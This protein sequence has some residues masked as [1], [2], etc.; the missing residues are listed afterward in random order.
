MNEKYDV[1]PKVANAEAIDRNLS[2]GVVPQ[3]GEN[4]KQITLKALKQAWPKRADC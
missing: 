3:K 4:K 2:A 1:D